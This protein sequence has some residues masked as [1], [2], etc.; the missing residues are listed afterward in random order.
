MTML[1]LKKKKKKTE[2]CELLIIS[3]GLRYVFII[4]LE[5]KTRAYCA[6]VHWKRKNNL[7][8]DAK[9]AAAD[10][11]VLRSHTIT[12]QISQCHSN[13]WQ[14]KTKN[15]KISNMTA[16]RCHNKM[17]PAKMTSI[18]YCVNKI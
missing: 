2:K 18:N 13:V 1:S 15:G 16:R 9:T 8:K 6:T 4:A 14:E 7:Q 17:W 12:K 10:G 5:R 3:V 11:N